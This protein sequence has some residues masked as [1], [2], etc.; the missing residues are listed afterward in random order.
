MGGPVGSPLLGGKKPDWHPWS[1]T[2]TGQV[3]PGPAKSAP[4]FPGEQAAFKEMK[5]P[6]S[7]AG[8]GEG[9]GPLSPWGRR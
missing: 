2:L 3:P 7:L 4:V 9:T 8:S 1:L 6:C 5:T